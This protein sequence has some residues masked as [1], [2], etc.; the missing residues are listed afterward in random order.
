MSHVPRRSDGP[1][2]S[3]GRWD[4]ALEAYRRY[5]ALASPSQE[6]PCPGLWSLENGD[7]ESH[8]VQY[9]PGSWQSKVAD[10]LADF[11]PQDAVPPIIRPRSLDGVR[12]QAR[13]S[14]ALDARDRALQAWRQL[15]LAEHLQLS[16]LEETNL[17]E[18]AHPD[19]PGEHLMACRNP[20]L[21]AKR[22][23][24][25]QDLLASTGKQLERTAAASRRGLP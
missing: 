7:P 14:G 19:F 9:D 5:Q 20:F 15:F 17:A 24:K 12:W 2:S 16:L 3:V 4:E 21:E 11:R 22:K 8:E 13:V 23:R 25:R 10:L 6:V 1:L 18:I